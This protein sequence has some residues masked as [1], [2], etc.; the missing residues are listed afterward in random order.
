MLYLAIDQHA[1]QITVCLRNGDGDTLLR[2]QVSTRAEK[3]RRSFSSSPRWTASSWR[4]SK[5]VGSM[6]G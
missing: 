3:S 6:I 4:S 1:K 5:S 2:R